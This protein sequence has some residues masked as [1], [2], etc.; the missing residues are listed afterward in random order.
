[1]PGPI[2]ILVVLLVAI[3][4]G[5]VMTGAVVAGILGWV[6][7]DNGDATHEGSELIELS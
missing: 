5:V 6:L 4:V 7:R 1:M 3:P 2:I